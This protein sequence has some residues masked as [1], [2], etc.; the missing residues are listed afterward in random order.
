MQV[1][2]KN[3]KDFGTVNCIGVHQVLSDERDIEN[4]YYNADR[5]GFNRIVFYVSYS[6][7]WMFDSD[8]R[9]LVKQAREVSYED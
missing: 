9:S 1:L 3:V 5:G 2:I 7:N 6:S 4:A 8:F